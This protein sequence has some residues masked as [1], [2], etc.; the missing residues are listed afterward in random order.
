MGKLFSRQILVSTLI[1]VMSIY[2]GSLLW[3]IHALKNQNHHLVEDST[4]LQHTLEMIQSKYSTL[5]AGVSD[6]DKSAG[7]LQNTIESLRKQNE[8]IAFQAKKIEAQLTSA[9]DEKNYLEEILINK[10]KEIEAL[11]NQHDEEAVKVAANS[12]DQTRSSLSEN[13]AQTGELNE[14]NKILQEKLGSLYQTTN[15]KM[16]EI[17][18]A[19]IALSETVSTAQKKIEDE[20][21][22]VNLGSV[23]TKAMPPVSKPAFQNEIEETQIPKTP[24]NEGHVLAINNEHGFVVIDIGK[25]DNLPADAMLDVKK[26]GISIATLSV[27]EIRD[28]MAACNI[29]DVL[30]GQRIEINDTVSILK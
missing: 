2:S 3:D 21:S 13:S 23:T 4:A 30:E 7:T 28:V 27:L 9:K 6:R 1:G 17:N 10:T 22:T 24:K 14:Q 15:E 5:L 19:K 16:H 25:V 11:K 29:K 18:V 26:N 20:W 8:S 12:V